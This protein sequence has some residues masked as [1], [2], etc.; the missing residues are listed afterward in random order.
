MKTKEHSEKYEF[1]T[2]NRFF[3][4]AEQIKK[5]FVRIALKFGEVHDFLP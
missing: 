2:E 4:K 3:K 5:Y 1:W